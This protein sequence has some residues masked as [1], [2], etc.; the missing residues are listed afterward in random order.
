MVHAN[1][2]SYA[3]TLK[4]SYKFLILASILNCFT[5]KCAWSTN[6]EMFVVL[7]ETMPEL[8]HFKNGTPYMKGFCRAMASH[9]NI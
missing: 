4:I 8:C 3:Q 5:L 6:V 7:Q 1:V 9:D 2:T